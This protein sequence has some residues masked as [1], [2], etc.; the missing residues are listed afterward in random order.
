MVVP[1]DIC[2]YELYKITMA[3]EGRQ[4][5]LLIENDAS[6]LMLLRDFLS[7]S[8]YIVKTAEDGLSGLRLLEEEPFDIVI[9]DCDMPGLNGIELTSLGR[10]MK[11]SL[12]IIGISAKEKGDEFLK[13]GAD[14]FIPKPFKLSELLEAIKKGCSG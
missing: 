5:I 1:V 3:S 14:L 10:A 13:A 4:R 12:F 2:N 7:L 6:I 8:G 9:T 11:P